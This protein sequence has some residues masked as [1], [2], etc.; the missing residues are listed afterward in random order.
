MTERAPSP[1]HRLPP[2]LALWPELRPPVARLR[3]SAWTLADLLLASFP[4]AASLASDHRIAK[5][6]DTTP[7]DH[8]AADAIAAVAH[9]LDTLDE[10][11]RPIILVAPSPTPRDGLDF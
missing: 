6:T 8:I 3:V 7:Y 1:T 10:L 2:A 4:V 9:L 11:A 5:H